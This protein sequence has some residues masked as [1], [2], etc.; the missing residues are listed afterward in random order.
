MMLLGHDPEV[1][2]ARFRARAQALADGAPLLAPDDTPDAERRRTPAAATIGRMAAE[3]GIFSF[4]FERRTHLPLPA[5]WVPADQQEHAEPPGW[6]AG[7]LPERKYQSFQHDLIAASFHPHHRA[8]WGAHELC[9]GL[10][11]FGW[12][13]GA[14]PFFHATAGR[15][16]ELLPVA[17]WYFF[18]EAN[19][20][21]CPDHQ[22]GGAL[23]RLQCHRCEAL[24]APLADDDRALGH[25][26][27]GLAFVDRELAAIARST[28]LG[29]PVPHRWATIDLC[30]DGVAY[31]HAHALRLG[32]PAFGA[33]I[34]RFC[35]ADGGWSP[36]LDALEARVLAVLGALLTDGR[37]PDLAPSPDH[38]RWRWIAQDLAWRTLSCT[39]WRSP[40][41]QQV[42]DACERLV[43][44]TQAADA[45]LHAASQALCAALQAAGD[46]AHDVA[47]TG[48]PIPGIAPAWEALADGLSSC[49]PITQ[50]WLDD[51]F[52]PTVQA[53]ALDDGW[54]RAHVAQRFS[55]WL[56]Q[57]HPGPLADV[58]RFEAAVV[59]VPATPPPAPLGPPAGPERRLADGYVVVDFQ[60]DVL[61]LVERIDRG[62]VALDADQRLLVHAG[63]PV[64]VLPT[65]LIL[66]R[67]EDGDLLLL[68]ID[69]DAGR[70]LRSLGEG[71][72]PDLPPDEQEALEDH[73]ALVP[74]AWATRWPS[75]P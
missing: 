28:R 37:A 62:D 44:A 39:G 75:R 53:F 41:K 34:E 71:A 14:T 68:D 7:I 31:A 9:H 23:F 63:P 30:S 4:H 66:G 20:R 64:D 17:L 22:G 21:R 56:A 15:L 72:V 60:T 55:T 32:S 46:E 51:A 2:A 40:A 50:A 13:P 67:Q 24:A 57:R 10:V 6:D 61:D 16:A 1:V 42:L 49:M 43:V 27:D 11:G 73:G 8:K 74:V 5:V 59:T 48:Y 58:A 12:T 54:T 35:V 19:L 26:R 18:D 52:A 25:L 69:P 36:T 38:G 33:Y 70:A 29:R 47:T 3:Q 45:D 65:T